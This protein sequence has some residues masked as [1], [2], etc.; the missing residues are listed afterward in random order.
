[1]ATC[2][3]QQCTVFIL[4]VPLGSEWQGDEFQPEGGGWD[5]CGLLQQQGAQV[6]SWGSGQVPFTVLMGDHPFP[7]FGSMSAT[8]GTLP[9]ADMG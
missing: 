1:M 6:L 8:A 5:I 7:N 2:Q 9:S 4:T 3:M